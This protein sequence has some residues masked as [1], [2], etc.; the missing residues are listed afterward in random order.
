M[1]GTNKAAQ[2]L[3]DFLDRGRPRVRWAIVVLV[4]GAAYIALLA[5]SRSTTGTPRNTNDG[6][7]WTGY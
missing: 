1:F 5:I 6:A 3:E 4:F 2:A 7:P